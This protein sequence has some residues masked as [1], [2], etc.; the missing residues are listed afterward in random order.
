MLE[1]VIIVWVVL[2]AISAGLMMFLL[3]QKGRKISK[4]DMLFRLGYAALAFGLGALNYFLFEE[5]NNWL[6]LTSRLSLLVLGVV[7]VMVIYRQAWALRDQ[8][9]FKTDSF[10]LEMLYL[11]SCAFTGSICYIAAPYVFQMVPYS[12][13]LSAQLWDIP[14][15]YM[16]PFFHLKVFDLSGQIPLKALKTPWL[17]PIEP[18]D[19]TDWNRKA[20]V[21]RAN[22]ELHDSLESEYDLFSW[23]AKP[24]IEA[25]LH[26]ELGKVFRVCIQI[27]R[28]K[29]NF[30]AIQ[31]MGDEY[32]GAAQFCWLFYKKPQLTDPK[33]LFGK[34]KY[35]NPFLSMAENG[36]KSTDIV[37]AQ[38][39]YGEGSHYA[40]DDPDYPVI[41]E[42]VKTVIIPR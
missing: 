20:K 22:F 5:H 40:Q 4:Y 37:V 31:D 26:I 10:W 2:L 19:T 42:D 11:F 24:F 39:I 34:T 16:L 7:N 25:P 33:S 14:L 29:G 21:I 15:V 23:Y 12:V 30:S 38:R 17:F 28:E 1:P 13:D 6:I 3:K 8:L 35:L 36:I 18:V 9:N 32:H 27:R 41:R